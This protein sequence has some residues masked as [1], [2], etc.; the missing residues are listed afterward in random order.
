VSPGGVT[1]PSV[2]GEPYLQAQQQLQNDHLTVTVTPG[3][4]QANPPASAG[5][6]YQQSVAPNTVVPAGTAITL[7][8]EQAAS[9]TPSAT[10]SASSSASASP[11]DSSSPSTGT[12]TSPAG[13]GNGGG[14]GP[15][16]GATPETT[17]SGISEG[18]GG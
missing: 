11:S 3:T 12:T 7:T 10:P 17:P 4:D 1:V 14:G 13:G 18:F 16:G 6:V 9:S 8:Y 15:F 5:D 2:L